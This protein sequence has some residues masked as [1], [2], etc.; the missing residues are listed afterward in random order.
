MEPIA[1]GRLALKPAKPIL[2]TFEK[3][4]VKRTQAEWALLWVWNQPEVSLALSGMSNMQQVK[5]NIKTAEH[6]DPNTLTQKELDFINQ[7]AQKYKQLGFIDCSNCKYCQPCPEGVDIPSIFGLVNEYYI[8]NM[9]ED[10]KTKYW[11]QIAPESRAKRCARCGKCEELCP[12]RLP[13]RKH[14]RS[15]AFMFEQEP[16]KL[17]T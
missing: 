14:L 10:V 1:G 9:S 5:E 8:K 3:A 7:I 13:I 17:K 16:P 15:A 12:Q 6:S 11:Q 2:D 4:E